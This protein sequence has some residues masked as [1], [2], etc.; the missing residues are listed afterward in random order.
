MENPLFTK[1]LRY[2]EAGNLDKAAPLFASCRTQFPQEPGPANFLGLI[3]LQRGEVPEAAKA[4]EEGLRLDPK[5]AEMWNNYGL[6]LL[7]WKK[8]PLAERCFRTALELAPRLEP[9][10]FNLTRALLAQS[11]FAE[12][13]AGLAPLAARYGSDPGAEVEYRFLLGTALY[14]LGRLDEAEPELA[15][16]T[17]LRPD[18]VEALNNY[19]ACLRSQGRI[20]E[21]IAVFEKALARKPD[22]A[23][24]HIN[25]ATVR[26]LQGDFAE[27]WKEFEWR[28]RSYRLLWEIDS[29]APRWLGEPFPG[30]TLLLLAEQGLGDTLQFIRYARQ[31]KERGGEGCSVVIECQPE[32]ARVLRGVPGLDRVI[33]RGMPRPPFAYYA[34]LLSLPGIFSPT[35]DAIPA[36]VPYLAST[37]D[38][39]GKEKREDGPLRV[40]IVWAGSAAHVEDRS[41]SCPV[42]ALV[43]LTRVEGVEF[44]GLQKFEPGKG[45]NYPFPNAVA[46]CRDFL[47]TARVV[48]GLDLVI[49][50]DTSVAHLAGGMGKP[51]WLLLPCHA[52]WRWL[53]DRETSPWYPTARL[54][55]QPR[56]GDWEGLAERLA[57]ELAILAEEKK[58]R[59]EG[60][61]IGAGPAAA[62]ISEGGV[63]TVHHGT[64]GP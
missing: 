12:T 17:Q 59:R 19:G 4:F 15:R 49:S 6:A 54:F 50:V 40:G 13:V 58:E 45:G 3:A 33:L 22:H 27:G 23:E 5:N 11:R 64:P 35:L 16:A 28:F 20:D 10:Q 38:A 39:A 30:Q 21:A 34:P 42:E 36:E 1:A 25:R 37:D 32:V 7:A 24:T 57:G 44:V 47:D 46:E 55:R 61:A 29:N 14:R 43:P 56:P 9:A 31:V 62:L 18:L 63:A 53:L 60:R 26:L 52:E 51:L 41:R 2:Y 48:A 8:G